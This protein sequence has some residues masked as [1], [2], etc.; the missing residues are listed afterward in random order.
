MAGLLCTRPAGLYVD[1][2][3]ISDY[4]RAV[5]NGSYESE[6]PYESVYTLACNR[7]L[8]QFKLNG[9]GELAVRK[10]NDFNYYNWSQW[11]TLITL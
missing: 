1:H 11:K 6:V 8:I 3:K 4:D 2:G 7:T 5:K 10:N 9:N